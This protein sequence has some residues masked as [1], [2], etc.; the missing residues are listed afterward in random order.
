LWSDPGVSA[1]VPLAKRKAGVD[2][3]AALRAGDVLIVSRLDRMFRK[4][5]EAMTELAQFAGR[6][7]AVVML[8]L[9]D[10]PITEA[11]S[12]GRLRFD[13]IASFAEFEHSRIRER[14]ADSRQARL[15][16]GAPLGANVPFGFRREG[17]RQNARL[18]EDVGHQQIRALIRT[19]YQNGHSYAS[20]ARELAARGHRGRS[21]NLIIGSTIG[22]WLE[23]DG[24]VTLGPL[25]PERRKAALAEALATKRAAGQTVGNPNM[26][27]VAMSAQTAKRARFTE[28]VGRR[29]ADPP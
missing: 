11:D 13:L 4:A 12:S 5:R 20:I 17:K 14:I 25:T 8:D 1:A 27:E 2:M 26:R 19:L 16:R 7:I 23:R 3:I 22:K 28:R 10:T 18:V 29:G 6:Q 9:A 15:S 24:L 21:G